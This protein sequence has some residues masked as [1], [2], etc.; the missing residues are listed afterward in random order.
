MRD[1]RQ[2]ADISVDHRMWPP[3]GFSQAVKED[4]FSLLA[5]IGD[6]PL[7]RL[8][9]IVPPEIQVEVYAKAEWFNPGGSVK[10][11]AALAMTRDAEEKGLLTKDKTIIDAT[12]GNTGIAYAMIGRILGYK[13]ALAIPSNASAERKQILRAYGAELIFTD[14][15]SG[16]DGAQRQVRQIVAMDPG[17]FYYPDQYNN[18]ANW[19][20]HAQTT[21][22]EIW[23]QTG[24]RITHFVAGLG[25]SG[26]FVGTSRGLRERNAS[27]SCVSFIPDLPLH[28]IEGLKHLPTAIVPGIYDPTVADEHFTVSTDEAYTWTRRLAYEEGLFVGISSGAAFA[29]SLR[30]ASR[31]KNGV[32]VT[33]FPDG[34]Q[35]YASD[36]LWYE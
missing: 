17:K 9:K 16:T 11:R 7:I 33:I 24:G 14:P 2:H 1:G 4:R 15:F 35:R 19:E 34:G 29:A 12:S 36:P 20:A 23:R 18:P 28:G 32:I 10:D 25:T 13:V 27:I 5:H 6:T 8:R 22:A 26:T 30:V 21:A 3:E 31:L